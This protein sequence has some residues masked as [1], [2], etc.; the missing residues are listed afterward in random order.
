MLYSIQE[1]NFLF[2]DQPSQVYF[3]EGTADEDMDI[4]AVA[5]VFSFI[6]NRVAELGGKMQVIVVD[7]AKLDDAEFTAET[8]EDWKYTGIKLVPPDWY[9]DMEL[10]S[11]GNESA[12]E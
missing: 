4:Q 7:H 9:E 12:G 10:D 6:R 1:A 11:E 5:K 8:I 3:P 2:L